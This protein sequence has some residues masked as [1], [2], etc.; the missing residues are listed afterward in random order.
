MHADTFR[1]MASTEH[2]DEAFQTMYYLVTTAAPELLTAYGAAPAD[3]ALTTEFLANLDERYPQGVNWQVILDAANYADNP[4]HETF[5]PGWGEYKVRLGELES[6]IL[7]DPALDLDAAIAQVESD[8][9]TIF[10]E[11]S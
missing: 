2:P 6:A 10:Q 4:S 5:L 8:L 1:I 7:S 11:G 9:T 3:P